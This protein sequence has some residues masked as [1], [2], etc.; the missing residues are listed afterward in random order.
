MPRSDAET[1]RHNRARMNAIT[2]RDASWHMPHQVPGKKYSP[3]GPR[4]VARW[5]RQIE[6]GS[7]QV[8]P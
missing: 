1:R 8:S 6:A 7:L 4:E 3:N 5:L 2:V